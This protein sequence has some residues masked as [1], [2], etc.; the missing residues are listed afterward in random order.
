MLSNSIANLKKAKD[1][2]RCS[3]VRLN[4]QPCTQPALKNLAF[5]R[6]HDILENPLKDVT[7]IPFVEDATTLQYALM[8]V[9]KSLQRG[10]ITRPLAGSIL[11]ALQIAAQNLPRFC[12]EAGHPF[13]DRKAKSKPRRDKFSYDDEE[14]DEEEMSLAEYLIEQLHLTPPPSDDDGDAHSRSDGAV[15][16]QPTRSPDGPIVRDIKACNASWPIRTAT[17]KASGRG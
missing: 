5:C 4:D 11:Y 10:Q 16:G 17:R 8:Q 14:D 7:L 13:A 9:I 3:Y 6:F 2:P 12:E 15:D 1:S